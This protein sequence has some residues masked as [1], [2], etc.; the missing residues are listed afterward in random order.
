[1]T[2]AKTGAQRV[3]ES[4]SRKREQGLSKA[5]EWGYWNQFPEDRAKIKKY[6]CIL[7]KRRECRNPVKW[8]VII[9]NK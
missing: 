1:M 8:L 9:L 4:E 5:W 6:A 2:K 3:A 7:R